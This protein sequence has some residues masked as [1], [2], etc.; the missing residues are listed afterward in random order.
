MTAARDHGRDEVE[1][2]VAARNRWV[3]LVLAC[4]VACVVVIVGTAQQLWQQPGELVSAV[5]IVASSGA[6][7]LLAFRRPGLV[8]TTRSVV[9]NSVG[10]RRRLCQ[11][12][13]VAEIQWNWLGAWFLDR[14]G[15]T[16][17][18]ADMRS[19]GEQ[20]L[21]EAARVL[22]VPLAQLG[23]RRVGRDA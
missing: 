22:Q 20:Q 11:R 10:R 23:P 6:L 18:V 15:K 12:D 4:V 13:E 2:V 16:L 9:A 3:L 21:A 1:F 8:I 17:M 7:A 14:Q 5:L 19:L